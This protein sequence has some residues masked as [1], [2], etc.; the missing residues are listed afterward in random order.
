MAAQLDKNVGKCWA[1]GLSAL[2]GISQKKCIAVLN[3]AREDWT[4]N[5]KSDLP[6]SHHTEAFLG[7]FGHTWHH[8]VITRAVHEMGYD[9]YKGKL[10]GVEDNGATLIIKDESTGTVRR[11]DSLGALHL[12]EGLVNVSYEIEDGTRRSDFE[13]DDDNDTPQKQPNNWAHVDPCKGNVLLRDPRGSYAIDT[14][15]NTMDLKCL[16]VDPTT[17][18]ADQSKGYFWKISRVWTL[19]PKEKRTDAASST[20]PAAAASSSAAPADAAQPISKDKPK[21]EGV[22]T[23]DTVAALASS[24]KVYYPY[25]NKESAEKDEDEDD[26][27]VKKVAR[28][29]TCRVCGLPKKGHVCKRAPAAASSS[30]SV[31]ELDDGDKPA[32]G[33]N[34]L[35][36]LLREH[37]AI[38]QAV[39]KKVPD[40]VPVSMHYAW[41]KLFFELGKLNATAHVTYLSD[42]EEEGE[43]GYDAKGNPYAV[44]E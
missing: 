30:S 23:Y 40:E 33:K 39:A 28:T 31:T 25:G 37:K 15:K 24:S 35:R 29:Y 6:E 11:T 20:A 14:G 26:E 19:I 10:F 41:T 16:H 18:K 38:L 1:K 7:E 8:Q 4:T 17:L 34:E 13:Q 27:P 5:P 3:A 44:V 21:R 2:T 36:K 9:F 43:V 32:F 42:S 12:F 22:Q